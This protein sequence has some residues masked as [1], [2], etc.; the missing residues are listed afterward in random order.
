MTRRSDSDTASK[1]ARIRADIASLIDSTGD[2]HERVQRRSATTRRV[3]LS[4][5]PVEPATA[6]VTARRSSLPEPTGYSFID[7][8]DADD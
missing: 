8:S 4:L 3:R 2:V 5:G 1:I 6:P 7:R